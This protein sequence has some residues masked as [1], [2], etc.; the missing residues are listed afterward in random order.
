MQALEKFYDNGDSDGKNVLTTFMNEQA[1][2]FTTESDA[3]ASENKL[4]WTECYKKFC[5]IYEAH[6]ESKHLPSGDPLC[7]DSQGAGHRRGQ[8]H[9]SVQGGRLQERRGVT[10][11]LL[12]SNFDFASRVRKL[13]RH[14]AVPQTQ[15]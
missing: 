7:S 5:A 13:H 15:P 6:V 1:H 4:E 2:H 9:G 14:D 11:Q 3:L 8:V 12:R 10:D